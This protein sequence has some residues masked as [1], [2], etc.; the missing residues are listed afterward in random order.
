[1]N[2]D[3]LATVIAAAVAAVVSLGVWWLTARRGERQRKRELF[4]Q[5]FAAYASYREFPY[6]IR[7]RRADQPAAERVRISS[8]LRGVQEKISFFLAWTKSEGVGVGAAYTHLVA[9]ARRVAGSAMAR[10]WDMPAIT[11]DPQMNIPDLD[12]SSL[13]DAE[14]A[15]LKAVADHLSWWRA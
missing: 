9:E 14:D 6:V 4:A 10:A 5:A 3:A 7:R 1:M 15:F 8:D 12:L 13:R 2:S 11:S